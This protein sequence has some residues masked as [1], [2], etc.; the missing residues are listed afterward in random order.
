MP[1]LYW[2]NLKIG[3][4]PK[5]TF[6]L[7]ARGMLE[8]VYHCTNLNCDFKIGQPSFDRILETM[9]KG[10]E[11]SELTGDNFQDL[12]LLG[13]EVMPADFSKDKSLDK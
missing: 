13:T 10:K 11:G 8:T 12:Q 7:Q 5:C 9:A 4:C 3:K 2:K 1:S 6:D